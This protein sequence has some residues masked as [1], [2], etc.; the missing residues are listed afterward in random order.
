M[1][2]TKKDEEDFQDFLDNIIIKASL[3]PR[4]HFPKSERVESKKKPKNETVVNK[5]FITH[6][7]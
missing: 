1:S 4:K 6:L 2:I 3:V 5:G 7:A